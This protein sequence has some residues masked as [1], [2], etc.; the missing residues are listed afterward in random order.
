M[1]IGILSDIHDHV[2]N[3]KKAH[4]ILHDFIKKAQIPTSGKR[5]CE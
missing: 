4:G 3:L 1:K 5:W 2:W